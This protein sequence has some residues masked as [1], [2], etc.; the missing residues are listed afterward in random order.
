M[1]LIPYALEIPNTLS[2][3]GHNYGGLQDNLCC[4]AE[5]KARSQESFSMLHNQARNAAK[6]RL[7][8]HENDITRIRC[9]IYEFFE[10]CA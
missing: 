3:S 7:D 6:S 9:R 5:G 2:P 1:S 4:I 10:P 8:I